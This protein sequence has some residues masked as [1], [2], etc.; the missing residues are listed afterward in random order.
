[1][2]PLRGL[3]ISTWRKAWLTDLTLLKEPRYP[4]APYKEFTGDPT[5]A[6]WQFDEEMAKANET[7]VA[8]DRGK[9][10][11]MVTFLQDGKPLAPAWIQGLKHAAAGGWD[12]LQGE[13]R[14]REGDAS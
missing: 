8:R 11:Q 12:E 14:F 9:K 13:R 10:L 5:L 1:M 4:A 2:V 3:R 6:F 7:Y